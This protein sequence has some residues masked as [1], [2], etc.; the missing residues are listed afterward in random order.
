VLVVEHRGT[1]A[2]FGVEHLQA[3]LAAQCRLIV[4]VDDDEPPMIWCAT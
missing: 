1:L 4:V 2:R 3:A